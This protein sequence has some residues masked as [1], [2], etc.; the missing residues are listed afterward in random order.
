[1]NYIYTFF[2]LFL[3]PNLVRVFFLKQNSR[4]NV[5]IYFNKNLTN[6]YLFTLT[7][8]EV[9]CTIL[10]IVLELFRCLESY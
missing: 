10:L 6:Y 9:M 2:I 7:I 5:L 4:K 1:M 8:R 3:R